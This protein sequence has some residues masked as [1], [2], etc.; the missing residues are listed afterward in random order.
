MTSCHLIPTWHEWN[1]NADDIMMTWFAL[2]VSLVTSFLACM[3]CVMWMCVHDACSLNNYG[4]SKYR[5]DL[6]CMQ[7]DSNLEKIATSHFWVLNT[8]SAN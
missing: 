7:A 5:S 2:F 4:M 8:Q 3:M 1:A 6:A